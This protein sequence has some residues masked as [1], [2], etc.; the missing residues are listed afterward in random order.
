MLV[1]SSVIGV[2]IF[3]TPGTIAD[4]L[5]APGLILTAWIAG[6]MLSLAGALANAEL[7]AMFPHAGG[8][9]VYLR[10]AYHPIAGF[11]VGWLSFF[12]IYAG[13]VATLAVGFA[14][15]LEHFVPLGPAGRIARG[16][17]DRR[18]DVV[19]QLRRRAQRRAGQQRHRRHQGRHAGRLG[20]HRPVGRNGEQRPP[21][22][23]WS[24][25]CRRWHRAHSG[26]H[27]RRCCSATSAGTRRCTSP[28]RSA[29]RGGPSRASLFA[30]LGVVHRDLSG[31]EP[32]LPLRAAGR[33][34]C[35]ATTA[36][37]SRRRAPSSAK[38]AARSARR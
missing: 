5:P 26:S 27:C 9:Y 12:V 32:R 17:A 14:E 33:R 4:I 16:G 19:D 34:S 25:T 15:G 30:G 21:L 8:D 23:A 11:L 3:L 29:T 22:A 7:S 36:S 24:P 1:V 38:P 2:G 28:A 18:R 10:E 20:G 31:G 6:G 37:A 13:T 35:A